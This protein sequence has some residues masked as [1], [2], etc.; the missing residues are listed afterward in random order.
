MDTIYYLLS[1]F[2]NLPAWTRW[3]FVL[4]A[5]AAVFGIG[6]TLSPTV[7][8]IIAIGLFVVIGLVSLFLFLIR[9]SRE[10]KAAAFG[11]DMQVQV[12]ATPAAISDPAKRAQ[13]ESLRTNFQKGIERFRAAGKDLYR[14]PWY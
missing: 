9:R 14:L 12:G 7:G 11:G 2:N 6:A 5:L 4:L 3:L 13:L 10:K 1:A 8:L